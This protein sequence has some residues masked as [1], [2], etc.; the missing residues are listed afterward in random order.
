MKSKLMLVLL[1]AI[2]W[3]VFFLFFPETFPISPHFEYT[4]LLSPF[5]V[6]SMLVSP[7]ELLEGAF[8]KELFPG[9]MYWVV[10]AVL[11][12]IPGRFLRLW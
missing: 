4:A 1:W 11:L 7:A 12:V 2:S 5:I 8:P 9:V 3:G 6:L 10:T